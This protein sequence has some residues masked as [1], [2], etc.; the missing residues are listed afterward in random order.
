MLTLEEGSEAAISGMSDLGGEDDFLFGD[1][2][3]TAPAKKE[4]VQVAAEVAA[5]VNV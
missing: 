3:V 2:E 4:V 5:V 1:C